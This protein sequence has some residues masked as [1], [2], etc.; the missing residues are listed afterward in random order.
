MLD[1]SQPVLQLMQQPAM[2]VSAIIGEVHAQL[3][4]VIP[5][6]AQ[7]IE[8][9]YADLLPS[10]LQDCI[11]Q[12][13]IPF[14]F[15]RFGL[16]VRFDRPVELELHDDEMNLDKGVKALV[17]RYGPVVF[18]NAY[19]SSARRSM[20][21][22][23]R[24]PHL[25]FHVDR[26]VNQPTPYSIFTRDPFDPVQMEPRT[27]STLLIANIVGYLQCVRERQCDPA[28]ERGT[29]TQYNLFQM[30]DMNSVF[31]KLV[32]NQ[33]WDEP[34]GTGEIV[35]QDNRTMLHASY[36]RDAARSGYQIGVRYVG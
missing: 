25:S 33:T 1:I 15:T 14:H 6:Y 27:A 17:D 36:Y 12:C 4:F 24:F 16:E 34:P 18:K 35:V 10:G 30:T 8:Q 7:E 11:R 22:R 31:G 2:P 5:D 3:S 28:T 20:G 32:L 23:N 19:L 13:G 9:H 29:R 26:S 21:H